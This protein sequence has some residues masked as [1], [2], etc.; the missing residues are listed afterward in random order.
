[1]ADKMDKSVFRIG[2][3]AIT[4][5]LIEFAV[6]GI[7][8][9]MYKHIEDFIFRD[10]Y[11]FLRQFDD[12]ISDEYMDAIKNA[13]VNSD[14]SPERVDA[15]VAGALSNYPQ[16]VHTYF[17]SKICHFFFF[18]IRHDLRRIAPLILDSFSRVIDL[19]QSAYQ[20]P[21]APEL[22]DAFYS[23]HEF[24]SYR[25]WPLGMLIR[26]FYIC[27]AELYEITK[28]DLTL[29]VGSNVDFFSS[30]LY[31]G[32]M[33]FEF[34]EFLDAPGKKLNQVVFD[35]TYAFYAY[36]RANYPDRINQAKSVL[37]GAKVERGG[38]AAKGISPM[39]EYRALPNLEKLK[40]VKLANSI[41]EDEIHLVKVSIAPIF[42][43]NY[44]FKKGFIEAHDSYDDW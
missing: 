26:H 24:M 29:S 35:D 36:L 37:R 39:E 43:M 42:E 32:L 28:E 19:H 38:A 40:Y 31:D 3:E 2:Y 21:Y 9:K 1:M 10:I 14:L 15:T 27:L 44:I 22:R 8:H 18:S 12:A 6:P 33:P 5:P 23:L 41:T 4:V 13:H 34:I 16:F 7:S 25:H 20:W 11:I 17:L 30:T